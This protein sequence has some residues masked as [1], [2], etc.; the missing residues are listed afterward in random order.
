M[1]SEIQTLLISR[2]GRIAAEHNLTLAI[3]ESCTGGALCSAIVAHPK[4]SGALERGFIVYS[5]DAKCELLGLDRGR[6]EECAGVS[7]DIAM[8]MAGAAIA[9]SHADV[10][11][12]I[13]GF[14][15]PREGSEEVGL[16]HLAV[17]RDHRLWHRE[18]HLGALGREAVCRNAVR[19]ALELALLAARTPDSLKAP[20]SSAPQN[21][22]KSVSTAELAP[23]RSSYVS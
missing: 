16:V 1:A 2:L 9:Q 14:A 19:E 8:A 20:T 15:G 21:N 23:V 3:A 6:V 18:L 17:A 4:A 12:A 11:I 7:E 10:G 22:A 5:T 13:T